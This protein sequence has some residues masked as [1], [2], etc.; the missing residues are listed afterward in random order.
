MSILKI[1][2]KKTRGQV[3]E[4]KEVSVL[5]DETFQLTYEPNSARTSA[6]YLINSDFTR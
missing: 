1:K 4:L 6:G 5:E 2:Y 3:S